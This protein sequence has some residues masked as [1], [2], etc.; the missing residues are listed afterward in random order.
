MPNNNPVGSNQPLSQRP[1][2]TTERYIVGADQ[3]LF[4]NMAASTDILV[5]P[6]PT[7]PKVVREVG[8]LTAVRAVASVALSATQLIYKDAS[9]NEAIIRAG[10]LANTIGSSRVLTPTAFFLTSEDQGIFYRSPSADVETINII[11][12]WSDVR[13]V[14]RKVVTVVKDTAVALLPTDIPEGQALAVMHG[15]VWQD[16]GNLSCWFLNFDSVTHGGNA[17]SGILTATVSDKSGASVRVEFG[18]NAIT[19]GNAERMF[20]ND[21]LSHGGQHTTGGNL[22][23]TDATVTFGTTAPVI[24]T[25]FVRMNLGE[26]APDEAG[27][28]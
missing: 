3:G 16:E 19:A 18:A 23:A 14:V 25:A 1:L 24:M 22:N 10:D 20:N 13:G 15:T 6:P 2:P 28:S 27:V 4:S 21:G 11:S 8:G 12:Q 7:D 17:A 26:V 9:G 5:I